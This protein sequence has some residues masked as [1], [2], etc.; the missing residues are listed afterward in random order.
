VYS[1]GWL[2]VGRPEATR[3]YDG[4]L[5][6][7][8][9]K[10]RRDGRCHFDRWEMLNLA[11]VWLHPNVQ[12]GGIFYRPDLLP[13]YTDR[14]G[15]WRSTVASYVI[16]LLTECVGYDYLIDHLPCFPD[17]PYEIKALLSYCDTSVH[18]GT[19]Y[20]AAGWR[21]ARIN[22]RGIETYCTTNV[23][24]L[25]SYQ[26]D[27]IEKRVGQSFRSRRYRAQRAKQITQMELL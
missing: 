10:D 3:C 25:T 11:R 19:I 26:R 8:S 21:L 24:P 20:R 6:Y 27:M 18:R 23:T 17:E 12:I 1:V 4:A 15:V 5:T 14:R 9:L 22:D 16:N 13:G 2:I 7:G